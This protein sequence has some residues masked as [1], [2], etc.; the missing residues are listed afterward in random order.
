MKLFMLLSAVFVIEAFEFADEWEI[1]KKVRL[2][3]LI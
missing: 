1:W 2:L 3:I